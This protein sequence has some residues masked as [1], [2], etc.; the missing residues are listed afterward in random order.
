NS[1]SLEDN[2]IKQV[3]GKTSV[4]W[5]ALEGPLPSMHK[6]FSLLKDKWGKSGFMDIC[7]IICKG[8]DFL[9]KHQV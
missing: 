3:I 1:V 5:K 8:L 2:L 9:R 7:W 6:A 4:L